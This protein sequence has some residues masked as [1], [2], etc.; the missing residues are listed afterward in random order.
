M[1]ANAWEKIAATF[2]KDGKISKLVNT[3]FK[4]QH[5]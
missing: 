3:C 2:G 5:F 1:K 4:V